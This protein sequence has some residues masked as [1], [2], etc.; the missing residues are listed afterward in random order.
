MKKVI[1]C[2]ILLF[3]TCILRAQTPIT[4][5]YQALARDTIGRVLGNANVKF[6]LSIY[7]DSLTGSLVY[8]ET[9]NLTSNKFGL[10]NLEVGS[11]NALSFSKIN[12]GKS[13][14]YMGVEVDWGKGFVTM[15]NTELLSVP[16]A[17]HSNQAAELKGFPLDT[18]RKVGQFLKFD[19][20]MW[21]AID[22]SIYAYKAGKGIILNGFL[23]E[24]IDYD[25]TNEI[26]DLQLTGNLLKITRNGKATDINM[27][28]YLDDRDSQQM[29]LRNDT[30]V[31]QRGGLVKLPLDPDK[32]TTNEIQ[33]LQLNGNILKVTKNSSASPIDLS[34]Y[35][36][37]DTVNYWNT[38]GNR[39][40]SSTNLFIGTKNSIPLRFKVN[41]KWF[42]ELNDSTQ[43]ISFGQGSNP[44]SIGSY[45]ISIG[46]GAMGNITYNLTNLIAIGDSA[47]YK[48]GAGVTKYSTGNNN[49]AIGSKTLYSNTHGYSN[50]AI[51]D[52]ALLKNGIGFGN[53]AIGTWSLINNKS[54][55]R[56][57]AIGPQSLQDATGQYNVGIG[58]QALYSMKT[59]ASNIGIGVSAL[60]DNTVGNYNIGIGGS[61]SAG[62]D[63]TRNV[64]IGYLS[65]GAGSNNTTVGF[66]AGNNGGSNNCAIGSRT[67][68]AKKGSGSNNVGFGNDVLKNNLGNFNSAMGDSAL[69]SNV[70]G[71]NCVALGSK[72]L[73]M[74]NSGFSNIGIGVEALSLN[75]TKSNLVAIGDSSLYFNGKGSSSFY[76]SIENTAIG[77]KTLYKNTTGYQNT[78]SGYKALYSNTS[79]YRNSA[80]GYYSLYNNTSGTSNSAFGVNSLQFNQSGRFNTA[81][82]DSALYSNTTGNNNIAVGYMAIVPFDTAS[83]QVRIGNT[84][85]SYAGVQVSWTTTS[86]RH[87]KKEINSTELG[88]NFINSL[89]P[90]SYTRINDGDGKI[91]YGFI[92]QEVEESLEN[93][94]VKDAGMISK[95]ASGCLGMRY[96]DLTAPIVKAIQEQQRIIIELNQKITELERRLN[97]NSN[98]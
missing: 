40:S 45:N 22:D 41:D 89:R 1:L 65:G 47:L 26:Q 97:E 18:S 53:V 38:A 69:W 73:K 52:S 68:A 55:F 60:S 46:R 19:G 88:L 15:S 35:L 37:M 14:H 21:K 3:I 63:G 6:R 48:I 27:T 58:S 57:V 49:I 36:A 2:S 72:A 20:S 12:W 23:V 16:Y 91:E 7:K 39:P 28:K 13:R 87:W 78:A 43:N 10:V 54:G 83:N 98:N 62:T 50:T 33:D 25:S 76:H 81:I 30:L 66:T 17:F 11:L 42:G 4:F 44:K 86:D 31:L 94:G 85:I 95:D 80:L 59:G 5:N 93:A 61:C 77:S 64:V 8:S 71:S 75:A 32:D 34:K 51:G 9:H 67:L 56:N 92:A 29:T 84:S 96:N 82:G 74:N 70:N 79:G 24:A 90:V